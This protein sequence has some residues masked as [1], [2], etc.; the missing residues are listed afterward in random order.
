MS[1]LTTV[2]LCACFPVLPKFIHWITGKTKRKSTYHPSSSTYARGH[3]FKKGRS[4]PNPLSSTNPSSSTH[5]YNTAP[6]PTHDHD[7]NHDIDLAPKSKT[8]SKS[9]SK[10]SYHNLNAGQSSIYDSSKPASVHMAMEPVAVATTGVQGGGG[11]GGGGRNARG[12]REREGVSSFLSE[13][14]GNDK[15][16]IWKT[17]TVRVDTASSSLEDPERGRRD[18]V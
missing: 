12:G 9:R 17:D 8:K 2:I 16:S 14:D 5:N 3:G 10:G 1:E 15:M 13:G 11:G 7:H 18:F 4:D 6:W